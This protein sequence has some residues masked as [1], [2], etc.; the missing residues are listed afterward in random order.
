[1]AHPHKTEVNKARSHRAW[2]M[3]EGGKAG[4]PWG[5]KIS[6]AMVHKHE[7]NMHPDEPETPLKKGGIV[8]DMKPKSRFDKAQRTRMNKPRLRVQ[9]PDGMALK[10]YSKEKPSTK[11]KNKYADG[12]KAKG[13]K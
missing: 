12:G 11:Q 9:M 7:A 5:K 10:I 13:A 2:K 1:M 3:A 6:A 8:S 4:K